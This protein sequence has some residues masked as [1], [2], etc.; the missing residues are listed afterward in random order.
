M[1]PQ[2]YYKVLLIISININFATI[3]YS[4]FADLHSVMQ[5]AAHVMT[6]YKI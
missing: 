5:V 2:I 6:Y 1:D 3:I 4:D